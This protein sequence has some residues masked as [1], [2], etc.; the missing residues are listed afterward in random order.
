MH[1]IHSC[2]AKKIKNVPVV[3]GY[4]LTAGLELKAAGEDALQ[5]VVG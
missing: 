3:T 2:V 5:Q 1:H 4:L